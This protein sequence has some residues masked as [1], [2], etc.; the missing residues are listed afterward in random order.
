MN[1]PTNEQARVP[2]VLPADIDAAIA[3]REVRL[4]RWRHGRPLPP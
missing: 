2:Q 3:G 4:S 1:L